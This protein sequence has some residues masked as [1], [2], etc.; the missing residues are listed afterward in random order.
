MT[1]LLEQLDALKAE[2]LSEAE[3]LS[4]P[5]ALEAFRLKYLGRKDGRLTALLAALPGLS[6]EERRDVGRRANELKNALEETLQRRRKDLDEAR[7]NAALTRAPLDLT[8]PGDPFLRGG[9]HPLTRVQ[10]EIVDIFVRLGF[11][12]AEGPEVE[13]DDNNFTALNHPPDHPARDAHDTFYLKDHKDEAG[14]PLLLRTHT[15]PVQIR[16]MRSHPPPVYIVAPGRVFRHENV[17]ATHSYVFHQV[18]GLAV[19]TDISLGDLKGVL[20][21]FAQRLF[22]GAGTEVRTRFRPS[23]FPFVE[24]GLEMDISCTL[25]GQKGCRV[26]KGTGWVEMLGSGLV[27]PNVLRA[28]GYD[29][30]ALSGWAFGIGVERVAMFKYGVDDMRLFY[31]NDTR[32][33]GAFA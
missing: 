31:E 29:A 4:T 13:T 3:G 16:W 5:E 7:L 14:R 15:S 1:S 10:E 12:V 27:H 26:C 19:D 22:G 6:P 20:S 25:C 21:L 18:E 2:S 32:F 8:L 23:F 9:L 33:L 11:S 28:A 17:D 24:P 30:D